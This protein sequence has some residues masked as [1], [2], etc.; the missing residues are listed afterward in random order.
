[1]KSLR[2]RSNTEHCCD[3][4]SFLIIRRPPTSTRTDTLFPYTTLFLSC[5]SRNRKSIIKAW[6]YHSQRKTI[7]IQCSWKTLQVRNSTRSELQSLLRIPHAV[8]CLKKK[9]LDM[10]IVVE[11]IQQRQLHTQT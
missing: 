1:M 7:D 4:V 9:P 3:I 8:F 11:L 6:M 2:D 10:S 5:V